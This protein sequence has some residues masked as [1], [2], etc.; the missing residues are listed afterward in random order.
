MLSVINAFI[1]FIIID[2]DIAYVIVIVTQYISVF[3]VINFI[4]RLTVADSKTH[5]FVR[6]WGWLDL[7]ACIPFIQVLWVFRGLR[8][9]ITFRPL[10]LG[11]VREDVRREGAEFALFTAIFIVII[12][13]E[14]CSVMVLYFE[15][16]AADALIVTAQDA[17]WWAYVTITAV[18]YGDMYPVT[19]GG[20]LAGVI[21]MT[22]GVGIYATIAGYFAHRL[23]YRRFDGTD[24][25]SG[26][27][28]EA[29]RSHELDRRLE[30]I[31]GMG[32][33][34]LERLDRVERLIGSNDLDVPVDQAPRGP[35]S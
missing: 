26:P 30:E 13:L 1:A 34:V 7:L 32:K 19:E 4:Y 11:K 3:F 29:G 14:A 10:S 15:R 33:E 22:A 27:T 18:G 9:Y 16:M 28:N 8:A 24:K 5:Y 6:E 20:R 35:K 12:I 2:P 25:R 23:L 21:L 31:E 17:L